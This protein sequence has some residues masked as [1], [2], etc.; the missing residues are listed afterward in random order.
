MPETTWIG[1][2]PRRELIEWLRAWNL[3][4]HNDRVQLVGV[5]ASDNVVS[6]DTLRAFLQQAYGED[7]LVRWRLA[8]TE[9]AAADEQTAVFGDSDVKPDVRQ[10][11][12]ELQSILDRDAPLLNARFGN[13]VDAALEAARTLAAFADYNSGAP[14]SRSRDWHMAAAVVRALD[15]SGPTSRAVYWAHNA[16]VAVRGQ[17]AG[18]LLR[19]ALGCRYAAMAMTFGAGSFV[20]QV[21]NDIDDRLAISTLPAAPDDSIESVLAPIA[22]STTVV[23]WPCGVDVATAPEWLR[24]PHPMHWVG[25]LW[26]PDSVPSAAL[27]NFDLL[28]DFD[29]LVYFPRV[30]A[31]E[32]PTDRPRIAPRAR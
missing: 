14:G 26:A 4:H 7:L 28:H 1:R 21:P 19:A 24:T 15:A 25:A 20:A 6:R 29:G 8:E 27:R 9:L 3:A 22:S 30:T 16:H 2:R 17:T 32:M 5:D 13:A 11:L 31:E 18:A 12:F 23:T 10:F